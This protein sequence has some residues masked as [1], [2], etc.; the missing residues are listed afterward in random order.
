MQTAGAA[1]MTKQQAAWRPG[2]GVPGGGDGPS[3][4]P[5]DA[6]LAHELRHAGDAL[7]IGQVRRGKGTQDGHGQPSAAR[8]LVALVGVRHSSA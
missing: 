5:L 4:T 2:G 8:A 6:Y 1:A 7:H 3:A